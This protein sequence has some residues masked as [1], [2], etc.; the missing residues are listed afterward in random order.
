MRP[1]RL[2]PNS[3]NKWRIIWGS[4]ECGHSLLGLIP[5][6]A[7]EFGSK[8]DSKRSPIVPMQSEPDLTHDD[9]AAIAALLRET[10][11]RDRFPLSPR[12]K[13][14]KAILAKLEPPA[15]PRITYPAP[16]PSERPSWAMASRRAPRRIMGRSE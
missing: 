14:L 13:G 1:S 3:R 8:S 2:V 6:R 10:I 11:E 15:V 9:K 12:I 16:K 5:N 7:T 4:G